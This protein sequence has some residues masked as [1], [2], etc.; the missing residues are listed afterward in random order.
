MV[1]MSTV[2]IVV[3]SAG[4]FAAAI[5]YI[6]QIRHQTRVRQ[7]ELIM[8]LYSDYRS[9]DFR[10][11]LIKV[12]NLQFKDYEDYAKK[13]GPW[14]S[15]EP[16]HKAMAMVAMYFEGIGIL[17]YRK[18][19]DT[20]LAYDLFNTP[21]RLFWE[22][23]RPVMLGLRREAKDPKVWGYFEYLYNEMLKGKQQQAEI[24]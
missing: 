3:A 1:D 22:K 16:A 12:A 13:C 20:S 21:I 5:H 14:F 9:N 8:R 7:T 4:V 24:G 10:E 11:A 15:D 18:L 2:S 17:L 6:S 23:M 19:I